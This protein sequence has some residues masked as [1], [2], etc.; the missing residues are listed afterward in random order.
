MVVDEALFVV[1]CCL[2]DSSWYQKDI[3]CDVVVAAA[4][5]VLGYNDAGAWVDAVVG[6]LGDTVM[7]NWSSDIAVVAV[8]SERSERVMKKYMTAWKEVVQGPARQCIGNCFV[9]D[10]AVLVEESLQ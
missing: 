8:G 10:R 3:A 4:Q 5:K 2:C 1:V 7:D 9:D 6:M